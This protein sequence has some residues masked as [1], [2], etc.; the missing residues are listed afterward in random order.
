MRKDATNNFGR[1][2]MT[3]LLKCCKCVHEWETTDSKS[4]CD[5]CGGTGN[6][7]EKETSLERYV[8][9]TIIGKHGNI[10]HAVRR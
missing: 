10:F 8:K 7:L 4:L 1:I 5:W 6:T 2:L 3:P 9:E